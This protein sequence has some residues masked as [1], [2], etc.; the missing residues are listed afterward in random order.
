MARK[1]RRAVILAKVRRK[2]SD[3]H[4][5]NARGEEETTGHSAVARPRLVTRPTCF[6]GLPATTDAA[7]EPVARSSTPTEACSPR[8]TDETTPTPTETPSLCAAARSPTPREDGGTSGGSRITL[9]TARA[10]ET[11]ARQAATSQP[12]PEGLPRPTS[13]TTV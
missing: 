11:D 10:E 1:K 4:R 8:Q 7:D 3:A 9:K 13:A 2:K 12:I 5:P 6:T